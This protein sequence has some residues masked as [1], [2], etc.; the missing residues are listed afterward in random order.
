MHRLATAHIAVAHFA[1]A[2]GLECLGWRQT[3]GCSASGARESSNDKGCCDY[4]QMGNSGYCECAGGAQ[5]RAAAAG[6]VMS[7]GLPSAKSAR[8][9]SK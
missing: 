4:V 1:L 2:S 5:V 9:P 3:G 7:A 8:S 6:V